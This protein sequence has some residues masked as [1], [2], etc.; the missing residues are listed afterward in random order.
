[1][2]AF[3]KEGQYFHYICNAVP[4]FGREKLKDDIF[5]RPEIRELIR[6]DNY[7]NFMD[8]IESIACISFVA[9][10]KDFLGNRK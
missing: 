9:F 5:E 8:V 4:G 7:V 10:V 3:D 2:R 1:M 6:N